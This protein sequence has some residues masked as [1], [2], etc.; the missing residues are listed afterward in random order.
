[1]D[2]YLSACGGE[3]P[4]KKQ[5]PLKP[6]PGMLSS[7]HIVQACGA[8]QETHLGAVNARYKTQEH[9][10]KIMNIMTHTTGH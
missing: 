4:L 2:S 3:A 5:Y 8:S 6:E 1:M 10:L 9:P 7:Q